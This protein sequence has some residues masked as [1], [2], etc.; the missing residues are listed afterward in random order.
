MVIK[1]HVKWIYRRSVLRYDKFNDIQLNELTHK[2]DTSSVFTAIISTRFRVVIS[3]YPRER[4]SPSCTLMR[5][6]THTAALRQLKWISSA[7]KKTLLQKIPLNWIRRVEKMRLKVESPTMFAHLER[8]FLL[9]LWN[10]SVFL[11][12]RSF[13]RILTA[14]VFAAYSMNFLRLQ[15]FFQNL[16]SVLSSRAITFDTLTKHF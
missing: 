16:S 6:L 7:E 1:S 3:S 2:F 11:S 9:K 8:K 4:D 12:A 13:W 10:L 15:L 14:K 5:F